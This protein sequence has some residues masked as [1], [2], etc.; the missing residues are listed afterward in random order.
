MERGRRK[1]IEDSAGTKTRLFKL[2]FS[3]SATCPLRSWTASM[4]LGCTCATTT[5]AL[6]IPPTTVEAA[7][8][9]VSLILAL[10]YLAIAEGDDRLPRREHAS[11]LKVQ[12]Y[13]LLLGGLRCESDHSPAGVSRCEP[14][15][16]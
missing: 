3:P 14:P 6:R 1:R 15:T 12:A 5:R 8:P 16:F 11:L 4:T 13:V 7:E 2:G 9:Q 10:V